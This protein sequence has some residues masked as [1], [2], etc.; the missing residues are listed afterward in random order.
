MGK[1]RALL[2]APNHLYGT[3]KEYDDDDPITVERVEAGVL[4]RVDGP[5][6]V[7]KAAAPKPAREVEAKPEPVKKRPGRKPKVQPEP[8]VE[9]VE[10]QPELVV[11]APKSSV[12]TSWT[13]AE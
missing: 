3:V 10:P 9:V 5:A 4:E 13:I 8:E 2:S 7:K 1:Y 11:E 6:P 12:M